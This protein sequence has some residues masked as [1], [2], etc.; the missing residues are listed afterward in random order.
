MN[1]IQRLKDFLLKKDWNIGDDVVIELRTTQKFGYSK[2]NVFVITTSDMEQTIGQL[3]D[4]FK[5]LDSFFDKKP[6]S[7]LTL[8]KTFTLTK[9]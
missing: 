7:E 2:P 3:E 4:L 6:V 9:K 8:V 1:Q 5:E